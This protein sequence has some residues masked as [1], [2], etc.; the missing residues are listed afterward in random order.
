KKIECIGIDTNT[1]MLSEAQNKLK[2]TNVKLFL[3]KAN[4]ELPFDNNTFDYITICNV[5]FLLKKDSI[6]YILNEAQRILKKEGKI[7]ILTPSGNG[8][9]ISLTK[10]FF[11]IKN[12]SIYIWFYATRISADSW[13][14]NK[15]LEQYTIKKKLKYKREIIMNGFAQVEVIH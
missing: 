11:S 7:I 2:E 10:Y 1:E 14:K 13:S 9:F 6:D 15:Y 5:L 8:N 12:L 4:T 3:I